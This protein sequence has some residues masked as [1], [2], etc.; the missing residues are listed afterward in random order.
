MVR[1]KATGDY[2]AIKVIG[3]DSEVSR[4]YIDNLLNEREVFSVIRSEFCVNALAT[5]MYKS[6]VCFVMEFL[7]G[8][9]LYDAIFEDEQ[10]GL[11]NFSIQFYLAE[12]ILGIEALHDNGIIHR[13]IKPANI[14][15]DEEGHVKLTDFG[16]SEFRN[17]IGGY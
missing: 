7:P 12:I 13:D 6:L 5:F 1:K 15:L 2:F 16:L 9:D 4:N 8:K 17:K 3:S 11:D 14:L 10:F